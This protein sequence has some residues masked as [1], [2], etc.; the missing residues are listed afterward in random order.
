[1]KLLTIALVLLLTACK[2]PAPPAPPAAA[3]VPDVPAASTPT[4]PKEAP[5]ASAPV[6]AMSWVGK[7]IGP[8]GTFL[9]LAEKAG[10]Y[11][12]TIQSL[13]GP[14]T[15]DAVAVADRLEFQRNGTLETIHAT[16]GADTG[17][18]WLLDKKDCLTIKAGE[19]FCRD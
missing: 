1:M 8:E 11:E 10:A 12:V 19:G 3:V 18:K 5:A 6:A 16:G 2:A 4:E 7:W 9:E 15:Y 13:D 17:M 14:A